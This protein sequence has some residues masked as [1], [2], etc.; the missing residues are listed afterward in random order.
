MEEHTQVRSAHC[1]PF[2][3]RAA[4]LSLLAPLARPYV[5][6]GQ[7]SVNRLVA[8]SKT[9]FTAGGGG[10]ESFVFIDDAEG[11]TVNAY[12]VFGSANV[13]LMDI[14]GAGYSC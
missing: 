14:A 4:V 1:F 6:A 3:L 7:I 2:V 13:E 11:N 10:V 9:V 8:N 12:R 5:H